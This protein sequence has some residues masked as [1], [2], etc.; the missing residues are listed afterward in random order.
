MEYCE[1]DLDPRIDGVD[2]VD[3]TNQETEL[4]LDKLWKQPSSEDHDV[5]YSQKC[6]WCTKYLCGHEE[7]RKDPVLLGLYSHKKCIDLIQ[8]DVDSSSDEDKDENEDSDDN[9]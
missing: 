9:S 8:E 6:V 2:Y 5:Q 3:T 7:I 4:Q 1:N